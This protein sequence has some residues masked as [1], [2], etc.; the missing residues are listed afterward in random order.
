MRGINY[1]KQEKKKDTSEET[2]DEMKV[3]ED[4][5]KGGMEGRKMGDKEWKR[6]G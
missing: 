4:R 5:R 1:R 3:E 6:G 2:I